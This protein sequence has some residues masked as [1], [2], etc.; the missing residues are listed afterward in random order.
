MSCGTTSGSRLSLRTMRHGVV[1]LTVV[2]GIAEA[3][4]AQAQSPS[5]PIVSAR[6]PATTADRDALETI[7]QVFGEIGGFDGVRLTIRHGVLV[8]EGSVASTELRERAE[9][10]AASFDGVAFVDNHLDL[11]APEDPP[12]Q[13]LSP[14]DADLQRAENLRRMLGRFDDLG[15]VRVEVA[16]GV[17]ELTGTVANE[18][19]RNKAVELARSLDDVVYVSDQ[20]NESDDFLQR[21]LPSVEKLGTWVRNFLVTLPLLIVAGLLVVVFWWLGGALSRRDPWFER[22]TDNALVREILKRV[23]KTVVILIG[24]FLALEILDATALVG[25]VLGTAGVVGLAL[26]FAFRD[27]VEN[28]LASIILSIRQPFRSRDLVEI[29]GK[30]GIVLRMNT[31]ETTLMTIEGN[32]L[33]LP[34]ARVFKSDIVNYTRAPR[35]RFDVAVGVGTDVDL[36]NASELG[37][38][39]LR[40]MAGVVEEPAPSAVVEE[41]GDSNVTLRFYGWVDQRES[42]YAK[43]K[44]AAVR[45]IKGVMDENEIDMPEPTY[46]IAIHRGGAEVERPRLTRGTARDEAE[47]ADVLPDRDIEKQ[48]DAEL[49]AADETDLLTV[50]ANVA[51][52]QPR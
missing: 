40:D 45:L 4:R 12:S 44:S 14:T 47:A 1:I 2:I 9:D 15:D 34:N 13:E 30:K 7:T 19:V 49:A 18:A 33:S 8:L 38:G 3:P 27:I 22:L 10:L 5:E 28:Y 50:P 35:R 42:D 32:H 23:G 29:D 52:L 46:R 39:I 37:L 20:L 41:L 6:T 25:A 51:D 16:A 11:P 24:V 26:G 48:V 17:V 36:K 43:V 21:I 31:R